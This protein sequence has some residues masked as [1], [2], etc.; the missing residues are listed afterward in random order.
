MKRNY[1]SKLTKWVKLVDKKLFEVQ[2]KIF[3]PENIKMC[4]DI[5]YLKYIEDWPSICFFNEEETIT[6]FDIGISENDGIHTPFIDFLFDNFLD[7]FYKILN[8]N[9]W[10]LL[11]V[12]VDYINIDK[13][14]KDVG[15]LKIIS[16]N[17]ES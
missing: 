14:Q 5:I 16:I 1:L 3:E 8:I 9:Y 17:D 15:K 2:E 7:N 4:F 10:L 11:I 13:F 12:G 6:M